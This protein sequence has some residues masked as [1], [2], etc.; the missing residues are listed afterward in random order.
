MKSSL[1]FTPLCLLLILGV[2]SE[3]SFAQLTSR[4]E[5]NLDAFANLYGYV[6]YFHPSDEASNINQAR[7]AAASSL[8]M[9]SVKDDAGL[10][11]TLKDLFSP[12]APT[13]KIFPTRQPAVFNVSSL[14]PRDA[15]ENKKI[16][17][18]HLG[19]SL[20]RVKGKPYFISER[21]NRPEKPYAAQLFTYP[22]TD[23]LDLSHFAGKKFT[24]TFLARANQTQRGYQ[25]IKIEAGRDSSHNVKG[26]FA[27]N[28]SRNN[29]IGPE[30]KKFSFSGI[31]DPN[32]TYINWRI[33]GDAFQA[34]SIDKVE[35]TVNDGNK[36]VSVSLKD[37]PYTVKYLSKPV[38]AYELKFEKVEAPTVY[39][40][41]SLKMDAIIRKEIVPGI[42]VIVPQCLYGDAQHTFPQVAARDI[43]ALET[44]M[45]NTV[46]KD[47]DGNVIDSGNELDIR[48]ANVIMS[49]N[50]INHSYPYWA[51][52]SKTPIEVLN[53]GLNRAMTDKISLDFLKSLKEIYRPLNDGLFGAF[54]NAPGIVY[55]NF[56]AQVSLGE[57]NE[58]IIIA[59][60]TDTALAAKIAPGDVVIAIDHKPAS[61][62]FKNNR[63]QFSGSTQRK[64]FLALQAL[65]AGPENGTV[66]LTVYH[67]GKKEDVSLVCEEFGVFNGQQFVRRSQKQSTWAGTPGVY[68]LNLANDSISAHVKEL[69]LAKAVIF[70]LRNDN[71]THDNTLFSYFAKASGRF[72]LLGIP[73]IDKPGH[74]YIRYKPVNITQKPQSPFTTQQ[75]YF[76]T[77]ASTTGVLEELALY[78][79]KYKLGKLIGNKTGGV[80]TGANTFAVLGDYQLSFSGLK[81]ISADSFKAEDGIIPDVIVNTPIADKPIETAIAIAKK[82]IK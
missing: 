64:T 51:R 15:N 7:F 22:F 35:L 46:H 31:I 1:N 57:M 12:I 20:Y 61:K 56:F 26:V 14:T 72:S 75:L 78:A 30:Q 25:K 60:V 62:A 69:R 44:D 45:Y 21:V 49:W 29:L 5:R 10:I 68:Y 9:L 24:V 13:I 55:N 16:Y 39:Y 53:D 82:G 58:E 34:M 59:S 81:V 8:K 27:A 76:I 50:V 41:A 47:K 3:A 11:K 79:K 66:L 28:G 77:D 18:Q 48:L 38:T 54:L 42:A 63:Q 73:E 32:H 33:V 17:W 74:Q 40:P 23:T 2:L 65:T 70:D 19:I 80:Y 6:R 52:A 36:N 67:N 37:S 71:L 4:Q 43:T